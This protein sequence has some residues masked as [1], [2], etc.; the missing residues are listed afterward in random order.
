[1]NRKTE[2]YPIG[3]IETKWRER[4]S[5]TGIFR[6]PEMPGRK[7]Y[8]LVMFPYTSGEL[9]MGHLKNYV[10]GDVVARVKKM[11]GYDVL[12]PMGWDAFG[13]PAENAAIKRHLHPRDWTL[14]NIDVSNETLRRVGISYDWDRELKTCTPDYYKWT[15][16]LFIKLH[17]RGLAY[18]KKEFVNWCPDCNTVLANE[19]VV[20]GKCERCD[21][22]VTKRELEQWFFRI[23]DYAERIIEDFGTL[24]GKWPAHVIKQQENW[25]GRSEGTEIVFHLEDGEPMPVFTTRADTM[26][27]V[28]FVTVAPES[29]IV[30]H[31]L[32]G[33]VPGKQAVEDYVQ[34]AVLTPEIERTSTERPKTGVF[35]GTHAVH[36]L[37]GEKIPVYVGD[38]VLAGYG[39]GIVMGVP[40]HDQRDFEFARKMG[41]PVKIVVQPG[42]G[43]SLDVDRMEAA[44]EEYGAMYDSDEFTG[45][46]SKEGIDRVGDALRKQGKGGPAVS[47]KMRDWL[48]S[49]QRY[50]GAPIPV[51]YCE[52]CGVVPVPEADLPVLLPEGDIDF[53]PEG[54]S[55][56]EA[57]ESFM[58]TPCPT[59]GGPARRDPDT[60]DT[61][62][63]SAWY[64][65]RFAD[66]RNESEAFSKRI[67]N[68]WMPVDQ[69]IGGA[70]HAT[71]HLIY[72]RFITKVLKDAGY[73]EADEPFESLFTQ[74][75]VLMETEDGTV[76][77]MSKSRGNFVLIRDFLQEHGSDVARVTI[78]FAAPPE[79]DFEWTDEGVVGAKR[80]IHRVFR[81]YLEHG[82][83]ISRREEFRS[84]RITD[85][86]EKDL[87]IR[88]NRT[89]YGVLRDIEAFHFNTALAKIMELVNALYLYQEKDSPIFGT[90]L[91]SLIRLLAP[92]TPFLSEELWER[93][94]EGKSVFLTSM[95]EY[96]DEFLQ[97]DRVEIAV[98]VN[99][100]VRE[101]LTIQAGADESEVTRNAMD[102]ERIQPYLKGKAVRKVVYVPDKL[103]NIV[104]G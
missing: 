31:I 85:G 17:E 95:P 65:L 19:Q 88:Y 66:P 32:E 21:T 70:E 92:F 103:I 12:H 91:H 45:L 36:P 67:A 74:G 49:R 102:L 51:V 83:S 58:N 86:V 3:E 79:K 8:V 27:G 10:M 71:K 2:E 13:L 38:Y 6:A 69:Y 22:P 80:F 76:E 94:G 100:K 64:F 28:T 63:D 57:C 1:M 48:I 81:L 73:V 99:G 39:T 5:R 68:L 60:M 87:F 24:R 43:E 29:R 26:Y 101:K 50:W 20:E 7:Y 47:Y 62:V 61:F 16:W 52:K 41:L 23:T 104:V 15:Q 98:Q 4:W 82:E 93:A 34:K 53:M 77:M 54:R 35:T 56:L 44:F 37:S 30:K 33:D 75:M 46:P 42:S 90:V 9:H 72:A 11:E 78:L 59:C 89:V 96:F 40:A 55:P 25:I 84:D 97:F 14:K 18:R